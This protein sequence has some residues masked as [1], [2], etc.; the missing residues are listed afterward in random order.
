MKGRISFEVE[1]NGSVCSPNCK[2]LL[3]G[4]C[5]LFGRV[6]HQIGE[7]A[8][9]KCPVRLRMCKQADFTSTVEVSDDRT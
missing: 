3:H 4:W 5:N 9:G 2:H 7:N 1:F 8:G 6:L